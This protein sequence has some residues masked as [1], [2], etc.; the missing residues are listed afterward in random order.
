MSG[1]IL[2]QL[3]K[4]ALYA[5]ERGDGGKKFGTRSSE[6]HCIQGHWLLG[7]KRANAEG[8]G[9]IEGAW[10]VSTGFRCVILGAIKGGL[11]RSMGCYQIG[12]KP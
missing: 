3:D 12:P 4:P 9:V 1:G 7:R 5:L 8:M 10:G 11:G 2:V 6:H